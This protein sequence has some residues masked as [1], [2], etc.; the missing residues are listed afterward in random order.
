MINLSTQSEVQ[1]STIQEEKGTNTADSLAWYYYF[2][3]LNEALAIFT[4]LTSDNSGLSVQLSE[5]KLLLF[6]SHDWY[7]NNNLETID[8]NFRK[9]DEIKHNQD[10]KSFTFSVYQ[11]KVNEN[12][13]RHYAIQFV[14]EPLQTLKEMSKFMNNNMEKQCEDEVKLLCKTMFEIIKTS[15]KKHRERCILIPFKVDSLEQLNNGGLARLVTHVIG[16]TKTKLVGTSTN[17]GCGF[18]KFSTHNKTA[19]SAYQTNG[20][21]NEL[22]SITK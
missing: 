10:N 3:Y 9:V 16:H 4:E 14:M 13:Y 7:Q 17:Q 20:T 8:R 11:L 19:E 21:P 2:N 5:K 6:L 18:W 15:N 22:V 12:E 1:V